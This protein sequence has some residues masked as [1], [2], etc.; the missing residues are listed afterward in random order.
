MKN[1]KAFTL[2]EL[3]V[4]IAIIALLLAII[5]PSL[6]LAKEKAKALVCRTRMKQWNLITS[7]YGMDNDSKFPDRY[8]TGGGHWWLQ[9]L[10]PYYQEPKIRLCPSAAKPPAN[11]GWGSN[12]KPNECWVTTNPFPNFEDGENIH[13][14][15]GPNGWLMDITAGEAYGS[16]YGKSWERLT[17]V[18]ANVPLF[19]D[20][21]WVDGWPDDDDIPQNNPEDATTWD[22]NSNPM[23]RFNIDRHSGGVSGVY[24]D[25]SCRNIGLKGLWRLKW[26]K[27]F[28][29]N[30]QMT[31][32]TRAWPDWM[33]SFNDNI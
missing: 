23:Q 25:G 11:I 28:N 15:L 1:K 19:L 6:R 26:H 18:T 9:P 21:W 33:R 12:R 7:M 20:C 30:N 10:R 24:M 16:E 32:G 31:N 22:I 3:L 14:S 17:E 8:P 4:V 27:Q 13:G 5:M 2:I 29:I